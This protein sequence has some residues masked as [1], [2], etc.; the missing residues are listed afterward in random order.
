MI[1]LL[2]SSP[3]RA[4]ALCGRTRCSSSPRRPGS[5][6][7]RWALAFCWSGLAV[8]NVLDEHRVGVVIPIY[9]VTAAAAP[10]VDGCDR[11]RSGRL[12]RGISVGRDEG[13]SQ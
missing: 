4:S 5:F 1:A 9:A 3:G 2:P 10:R 12:G 7:A 13:G 6:V 11:E 8:L